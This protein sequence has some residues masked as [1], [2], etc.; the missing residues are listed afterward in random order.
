MAVS[1]LDIIKRSMK[2]I[3][4]I[5]TGETPSNDEAVDCFD[6]LN[7]MVAEWGT[8]RNTIYTT[9]RNLYS[10]LSGTQSYT[11]GPGGTFNQARPIWLPT[12]GIISNNNPLQP[13]ELTLQMLTLD[14]WQ[15]I[16]VKNVQGSLPTGLYYDHGFAAGLGTIYFWPIPSV[17]GLQVALYTPTALTAFATLTTQYTFP[18]GYENALMFNLCIYIAPMFYKA[19][20]ADVRDLAQSTK[21]N[22]KR[23]NIVPQELLADPALVTRG[24]RFNYITGDPI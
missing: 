17:S 18:P 3:G 12:A 9:P 2:T 19:I 10:L 11:I 7:N 4:T 5:E 15:R 21:S 6:M 13:L 20:T 14:Q 1:A 23:A 16:P 24:D 22:I 8:E